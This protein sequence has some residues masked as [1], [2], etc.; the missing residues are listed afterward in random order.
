[1]LA[2]CL[3]LIFTGCKPQTT[4]RPPAQAAAPEIAGVYALVSVDGKTMP[5]ALNHEGTEMTVKSGNI[6]FTADGR[7]T[8]T[9]TIAVKSGT[10][11]MTIVRRASYQQA[12]E[13]FTMRW[14][15]FG[16]TTGTL[17]ENNFSMNNEG[18]IFTYR[19]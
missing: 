9:T 1:M 8:T 3:L 16:Q 11:D 5:C 12:G 6:V 2:L 18:M 7:C 4:A 14:E 15:G 17:T 19:K 10:K 13:Q